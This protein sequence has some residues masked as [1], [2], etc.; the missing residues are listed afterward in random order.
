[1]AL[2]SISI[3]DK[4]EERA[5]AELK[6]DEPL[7]ILVS[8]P[9]VL[10]ISASTSKAHQKIRPLEPTSI[11]LCA[12]GN[13]SDLVVFKNEIHRA[14]TGF[15]QVVSAADLSGRMIAMTAATILRNYYL[16]EPKALAVQAAFL[17]FTDPE[18]PVCVISP[19]GDQFVGTSFL[20]KESEIVPIT[21]SPQTL[22]EMQEYA[23]TLGIPAEGQEHVWAFINPM[24]QP[25]DAKPNQENSPKPAEQTKTAEPPPAE[26]AHKKSET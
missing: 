20:L 5:L 25:A 26:S 24:P 17:D 13:P 18:D 9:A 12:R 11:I 1:M 15:E 16:K 21:D 2:D 8:L 6:K 14:I 23:K 4:K 22:P 10:C 7:L 19:T 3:L